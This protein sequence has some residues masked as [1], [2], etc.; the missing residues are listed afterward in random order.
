MTSF[1]TKKP[2]LVTI[3]FIRRHNNLYWSLCTCMIMILLTDNWYS[4]I[5][6]F[7]ILTWLWNFLKVK[8]P[9]YVQI[10]YNTPHFNFCLTHQYRSTIFLLNFSFSIL[11]G[12]FRYLL[13]V[14]YL[15]GLPTQQVKTRHSKQKFQ[16]SEYI[17]TQFLFFLPSI[18]SWVVT[19]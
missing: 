6:W 12:D 1:N 16:V 3:W 5:Y 14:I 9:S 4:L 18:R 2:T 10:N 11:V 7:K 13:F 15:Y 8:S 17:T 19:P